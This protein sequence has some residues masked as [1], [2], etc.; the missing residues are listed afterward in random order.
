M[1][2]DAKDVA[3]GGI[4]ALIGLFMLV[5][6]FDYSIGTAREMGPGYYPMVVAILLIVLGLAIAGLS[7]LRTG[8]I[9]M[10]EW[11]ALAAVLGSVLVFALLVR[12]A[13]MIPAVIGCSFACS[14]GHPGWNPRATFVI[15][16]VLAV[17]TWLLFSKLLGL[18]MPALTWPIMIR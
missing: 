11:R 6:S 12:N 9:P 16:A 2:A 15:S 18:S 14:A 7:L 8:R 1:R 10:P 5:R 17:A 13:G 3:G 4:L